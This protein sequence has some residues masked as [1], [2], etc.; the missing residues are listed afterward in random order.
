MG[1]NLLSSVSTIGGIGGKPWKL[2]IPWR[3]AFLPM[4]LK[5]VVVGVAGGEEGPA[6]WAKLN[7]GVVG[8][9]MASLTFAD[10]EFGVPTTVLEAGRLRRQ[11]PLQVSPT[12]RK[13]PRTIGVHDKLRGISDSK[14]TSFVSYE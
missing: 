7:F 12:R 14:G 6:C 10:T 9:M 3:R 5:F 13:Q 1:V 2:A 8:R 11:R 4:R